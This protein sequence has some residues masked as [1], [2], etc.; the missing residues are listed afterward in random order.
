MLLARGHTVVACESAEQASEQY[1]QC[2][3]PLV[4]LDL[5]LPGMDG[6]E[7]C[8]W[9][10]AQPDGERPYVLIGTAS[11]EPGDLRR[12]LEAGADDYLDKPYQAELFD[13]RVTVAEEALKVRA[14]RRQLT[15]EL[16]VERDQLT[17]LAS[18][19]AL[20]KLHNKEHFTAAVENAVAA[21]A[22]GGPDGALFYLNL[23]HFELVNDAL[24][25]AAGDRLLV[26]IAYL[27]RNAVRPQDVV[28]RFGGDQF[29]VL[30]AGLALAETRLT[31]ERVR[32]Q[33]GNLSFCDSGQR[34][35]LGVSIG[36]APVNG[37]TLAAH[38]IAAADSACYSAKAR[39]RDRV[40]IFCEGDPELARLR[41]ETRR[42]ADLRQALRAH[43]FAL[44]FQPVVDLDTQRVAFHEARTF[45]CTADGDGR[46][47]DGYL[48]AAGRSHLVPEVDRCSLRLAA[49]ALAAHPELRLALPVSGRSLGDLGLPAFAARAC[50]SVGVPPRRLTFEV[51]EAALLADP[52][53]A[54]QTLSRLREAGFHTGLV[55]LGAGGGPFDYLRR[56]AF[57]YL[58]V[59]G[60]FVRAVA[61][62]P[63]NLAFVKVLSDCARHLEIRSVAAGVESGGAVKA[64]HGLGIHLA[65]GRYFGDWQAEPQW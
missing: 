32:T 43:G 30:Q 53:M 19:D 52:D 44:R 55:G 61:E 3:S 46:E 64:V 40:E 26:Q 35:Q 33:I 5:G 6:F 13:V 34:F 47:L 9:L 25:H 48:A 4:V 31:A 7:F 49:R 18:H 11:R 20:T 29:V 22:A 12:I 50:E 28:A 60:G 10:R 17:Y 27:L 57:D 8:R 51:A 62:N 15:E 36:V 21:A 1:R 37:E 45:L 63:I 2:F 24:G 23:D 42:L 39:G 14:A 65:Q 16:H 38:V 59:E 58:K 56:C 41:D 54:V